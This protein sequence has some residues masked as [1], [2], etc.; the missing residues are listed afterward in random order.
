[1]KLLILGG[2]RLLG[3]ATALDALS[4]GHEVTLFNRG[5]ADPTGPPGVEHV[6]GDREKDLDRLAG[7]RWDAVVDM[8][9][10]LPRVVRESAE[11]LRDRVSR[12]VFISSVSVFDHSLPEGADERSP[13]KTM[14][15]EA[16]DTFDLE[17]YG[18][19]K[20][21][22]ERVVQDV[23]GER[24][25]IVRPGLMVGPGDYTDRFTAWVDRI[26]RGGVIVAPDR[27]DMP[28]QWIDA[29]DLG[30]FILHGLG[31]GLSGEFNATG[32]AAGPLPLSDFL[33]RI[34]RGLSAA[35]EF[36]WVD[37]ATL[38]RL[39]IEPWSDLP[40]VLPYDGS[41]DGM[42]RTNV[43]KAIAAGL[44]Y[45]PLEE[46]ARDVLAWWRALDPPRP[47]AAGLTQEREAQVLEAFVGR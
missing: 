38:E 2:G 8:C 9:G 15:D 47:L 18:P 4:R 42:A 20:A 40:F 33:A 5:L 22:C 21:R 27:R 46:S 41:S 16:A 13:I 26:A 25:F 10:Y 32:P 11:A 12:Y 31:A 28:V 45:R 3:R 34:A 19:L 29:R 37:V 36:V 14:P 7:R 39:G 24:A 35:P 43:S 17:H 30:A 6:Q 1:M 23:F 44:E